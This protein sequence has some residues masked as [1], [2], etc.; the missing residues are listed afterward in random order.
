MNKSFRAAYID[1][2]IGW[3]YNRFPLIDYDYYIISIMFRNIQGNEDFI[4]HRMEIE[5]NDLCRKLITRMNRKP[6]SSKRKHYNP[7]FVIYP[8][9][10]VIKSSKKS[11]IKEIA[12]N[13]GLHFQGI[14]AI[15]KSCRLKEDIK[16]HFSNNK[17]LYAPKNGPIERVHFELI[18]KTHSTAI[19]YV[20]KQFKMN[21]F[22][23]EHFL[24]LPKCSSEMPSFNGNIHFR[25]QCPVQDH[26]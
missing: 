12:V 23:L 19:K 21:N 22:G 25:H 1:E 16:T 2:L 24:Y 6:N 15:P 3:W 5:T 8:D 11:S 13:N 17:D 4:L 10:P 9:I 18:N 14:S 26:L 7:Q 20:L